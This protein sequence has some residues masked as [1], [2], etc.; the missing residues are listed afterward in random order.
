MASVTRWMMA[1]PTIA[2]SATLQTV[3]TVWGLEI[4]NPT[5]IGVSV[6][7]RRSATAAIVSSGRRSRSP[8]IPATE[9]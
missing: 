1:E 5:Q 9:M 7:F 2:P 4:P 8:V 3:S 6:C